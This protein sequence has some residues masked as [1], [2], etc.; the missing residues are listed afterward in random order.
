[1]NK[2]QLKADSLDEAIALAEEVLD[3]FNTPDLPYIVEYRCDLQKYII[4]FDLLFDFK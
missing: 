3:G 1:M 2:L 4:T